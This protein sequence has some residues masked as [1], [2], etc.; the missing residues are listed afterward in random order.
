MKLRVNLQVSG[1]VTS[2]HFA[3]IVY[4]Q[5]SNQTV[6]DDV[7]IR[8]SINN[9]EQCTCPPQYT[10]SIQFI[11]DNSAGLFFVRQQTLYEVI[12]NYFFPT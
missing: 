1:A 11:L 8:G 9:V 10:V 2:L 12:V 5:E 7:T 4:A 3:E 6:D